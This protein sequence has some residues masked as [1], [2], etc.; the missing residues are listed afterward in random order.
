MKIMLDVYIL[1]G[2]NIEEV[3][4]MKDYIVV[5]HLHAEKLSVITK[6]EY[7]RAVICSYEPIDDTDSK[8]DAELILN[9]ICEVGGVQNYLEEVWKRTPVKKLSRNDI[10]KKIKAI[11][12]AVNMSQ[13]S[14]SM[15]MGIPLQTLQHWEQ[16]VS[17]PS[18]SYVNIIE[19]CLIA[20]GTLKEG[21]KL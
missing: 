10:V 11:R 21:V 14:F 15:H 6:E 16:G 5:R 19:R 8:E 12:Q 2:Y 20:E 7:N 1:V 18:E 4:N 3:I 9:H 17:V 13:R